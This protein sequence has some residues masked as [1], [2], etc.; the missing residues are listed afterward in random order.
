[1]NVVAIVNVVVNMVVNSAVQ[2]MKEH[3]SSKPSLT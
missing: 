3:A 1:M 2:N